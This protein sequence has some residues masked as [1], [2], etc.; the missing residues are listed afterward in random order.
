[1]GD[2]KANIKISLIGL[3][4]HVCSSS[5]E[6]GVLARASRKAWKGGPQKERFMP[7]L[8]LA[9]HTLVDLTK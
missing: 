7:R 5:L 4:F 2:N 6:D 9:A 1:M 3:M 8:R